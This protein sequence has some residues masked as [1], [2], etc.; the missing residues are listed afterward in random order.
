MTSCQSAERN[1]NKEQEGN[2]NW[3][4]RPIGLLRVC[5]WILEFYLRC[6]YARLAHNYDLWPENNTPKR[7]RV[8]KVPTY[9]SIQSCGPS[10]DEGGCPQVIVVGLS[11]SCR[12]VVRSGIPPRH[13]CFVRWRCPRRSFA[14]VLAGCCWCREVREPVGAF[15]RAIRRGGLGSFLGATP[16]NECQPIR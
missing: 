13:M 3:K 7:I 1:G 9:V 15:P 8:L 4:F 10:D 16:S 2:T 5:L 12:R 14:L 11:R 6:S